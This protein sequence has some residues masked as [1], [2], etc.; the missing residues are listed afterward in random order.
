[1]GR[2]MRRGEESREL[3]RIRKRRGGEKVGM[4]RRKEKKNPQV[5]LSV[6]N[7]SVLSCLHQAEVATRPRWHFRVHRLVSGSDDSKAG[8][9]NLFGSLN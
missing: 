7:L 2:E 9:C 1:M 4:L 6:I 5:K 3:G 8:I